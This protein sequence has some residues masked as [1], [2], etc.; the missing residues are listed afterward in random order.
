MYNIRIQVTPDDVYVFLQYAEAQ[1][2]VL[3]AVQVNT[4][5]SF[6]G[7]WVKDGR[8]SEPMDGFC[9]LFGVPKFLRQATRLMGG[10]ELQIRED[11][12]MV[13]QVM[14]G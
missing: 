10:L 3:P 7:C 9:D 8:H 4:V 14:L 2:A 5:Q 11:S 13:K 6:C 1:H 12:L